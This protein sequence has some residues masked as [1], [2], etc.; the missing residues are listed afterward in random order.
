MENEWAVYGGW[1]SSIG[2]G[3]VV[4]EDKSSVFIQY[5]ETQ[6]Y[7]PEC[8]DVGYVK[9]FSNSIDAIKECSKASMFSDDS[10]KELL[11]V[12]LINFPS[13]IKS[14]EKISSDSELILK[15]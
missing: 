5:C 14:L 1:C 9:R 8:W 15:K 6:Q 2:V 3:K 11:R 13:Q 10:E 12:F 4:Q 7:P